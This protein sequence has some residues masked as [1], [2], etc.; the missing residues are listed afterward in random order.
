MKNQGSKSAASAAG[1]Q[2]GRAGGIDR[3]QVLRGA[4]GAAA[5]L[6]AAACGVPT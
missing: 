3:R 5:L 2:Q 4:A 1:T 6:G